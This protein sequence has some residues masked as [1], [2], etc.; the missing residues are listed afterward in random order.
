M[1]GFNDYII[2]MLFVA[3]VTVLNI[4]DFIIFLKGLSETVCNVRQFIGE[5]IR[6]LHSVEK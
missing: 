6:P 2:Y 3:A 1:K 4:K 5:V